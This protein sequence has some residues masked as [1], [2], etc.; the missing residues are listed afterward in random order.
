[1]KPFIRAKNESNATRLAHIVCQV[2]FMKEISGQIK[3]SA[4]VWHGL[5][6]KQIMREVTKVQPYRRS[7]LIEYFYAFKVNRSISSEL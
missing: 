5:G 1:M 2:F 6:S 3:W 7:R 4:C